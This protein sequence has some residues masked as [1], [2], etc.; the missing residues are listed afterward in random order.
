[1]WSQAGQYYFKE[2]FIE[3]FTYNTGGGGVIVEFVFR[4]IINKFRFFLWKRKH[5]DGKKICSKK[6]QTT[7]KN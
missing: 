3:A 7:T 4:K 2:N 5:N 1:M 6:T